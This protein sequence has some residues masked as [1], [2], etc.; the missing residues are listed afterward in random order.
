MLQKRQKM[1][2]KLNEKHMTVMS[3]QIRSIIKKNVSKCVSNLK[4]QWHDLFY[5][6]SKSSKKW[7]P[8]YEIRHIHGAKIV[9]Y[10]T[11]WHI[12]MVSNKTIN[13]TPSTHKTQTHFFICIHNL[14]I[15]KII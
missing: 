5:T 1:F 4:D 12:N 13:I 3:T 15:L 7:L 10:Y 2:K 6:E 11:C 9:M 8:D 14:M